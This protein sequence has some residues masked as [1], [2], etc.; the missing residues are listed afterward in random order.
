MSKTR[1]RIQAVI[2]SRDRLNYITETPTNFTWSFNKEAVR[3]TEVLIQSIQFP[4]TF[5]TIN[6]NNNVLR[7]NCGTTKSINIPEGNYTVT[8]IIATLNLA[9][10]NLTDPVTGFNYNGFPGETFSVSFKSSTLKLSITNVNPFIIYSSNFDI[11]STL[12]Y[13]LGFHEDSVL[14]LSTTADSVINLAGPSYIQIKSN[15]LTQPTQHKP[16]YK[17]NS[18]SNSLFILPINAS[19]G[20]FISTDIQIPI[21]YTFKKDILPND[22]IDISVVDDHGNL[23]DL[24][25]ADWS[26]YM[27]FI[28]E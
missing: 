1:E 22:I 3:I 5:Y 10:N 16:L 11:L 23:L 27:I 13:Y 21:R 18:Y 19:S 25:G 26:M 28:T 2:N 12:A 4:F 17:D 9:L 24:N 8:S 14:G 7:V 20:A 6:S 15:Y